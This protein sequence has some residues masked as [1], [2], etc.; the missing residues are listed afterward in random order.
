MYLI[1]FI[2]IIMLIGKY[3]TTITRR[4]IKGAHRHIY[5]KKKTA[6]LFAIV[7]SVFHVDGL[8]FRYFS[9]TIHTQ[10]QYCN[11]YL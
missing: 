5:L 11:I 2:I 10:Q 1:Q 6:N 8:F 3:N 4:H 9:Y 7:I